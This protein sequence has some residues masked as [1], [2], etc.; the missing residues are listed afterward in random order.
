[1]LTDAPEYV[2]GCSLSLAGRLHVN[3][4]R[5]LAVC[6]PRGGN[7][8]CL[9]KRP[10]AAAPATRHLTASSTSS[11][12]V[13]LAPPPPPS[14]DSVVIISDPS[15]GAEELAE[16]IEAAGVDTVL[17]YT[18]M[19][20]TQE[21][22][23]ISRTFSII[24]ECPGELCEVDGGGTVQLFMAE[25]SAEDAVEVRLVGLLLRGGY[26]KSTGGAMLLDGGAALWVYNSTIQECFA[27]NGGGIYT[28]GGAVTLLH[29]RVCGNKASKSGG[30]LYAAEGE[31]FLDRSSVWG[32]SADSDGGGIYGDPAS[33]V[34]VG[35]HSIVGNNTAG[36]S[37]GGIYVDAD[38]GIAVTDD[39]AVRGNVAGENGGGIFAS[40]NSIITVTW[41]SSISNNS[42]DSSGGGIYVDANSGIA[43]TDDSAVRGNVAGMSGGGI[44]AGKEGQVRVSDHSAVTNN[45][46]ATRHGGGIRVKT[47]SIVHVT[48]HSAVCYN[49]AD[50]NS[51]GGGIQ[52]GKQSEVELDSSS[53]VCANE[54]GHGGGV[55]IK[56][57]SVLRVRG[58]SSVVRNSAAQGS[59]GGMFFQ[60]SGTSE[61]VG[62]SAVDENYALDDGGGIYASGEC[63]WWIAQGS[64]VS[65]ND[66]GFSGGGLH[67]SSVR[68]IRVENSTVERNSA[69]RLG[70]GIYAETCAHVDVASSSVSNNTAQGGAG[71]YSF[72]PTV[73]HNVVFYENFENGDLGAFS[74]GGTTTGDGV[75]EEVDLWDA[76]YEGGRRKTGPSGAMW[77]DYYAVALGKNEEDLISTATLTT[78]SYVLKQTDCNAN[79][80]FGYHMY[81]QHVGNL[82][83]QL[84][85]VDDDD[86]IDVGAWNGQQHDSSE[87]EYTEVS[88]NISEWVYDHCQFKLRFVV[89]PTEKRGDIAID[90]VRVESCG[91]A[92]L[93][94]PD[95]SVLHNMAADG[96]GGGVFMKAGNLVLA[97]RSIIGHNW[98]RGSGG[99][100]HLGQGNISVRYSRVEHNLALGNGGGIFSSGQGTHV[101]VR[102]HSQVW[103]NTAHGYGGAVYGAP[104]GK[105]L[106]AEHATMRE[107]KAE[108]KGGAIYSSSGGEVVLLEHVMLFGNAAVD[109]GG[110]I[111]LE[112]GSAL[113]VSDSLLSNNRAKDGAAAAGEDRCFLELAYGT[114]VAN[115]SAHGSGGAVLARK[116]SRVLLRGG[117]AVLDNS[118]QLFGGG[119]FAEL[120]SAVQMLPG[121]VLEGNSAT[122]QGGS[123]YLT[124]GSTVSATDCSVSSGYAGD[125]GGGLVV[126]KLSSA[127]LHGTRVANCHADFG[128]GASVGGESLLTV[129]N[130]TFSN[131]HATETGGALSVAAEARLSRMLLSENSAQYGGATSAE[132]GSSMNVS[133]VVYASNQAQWGGGMAVSSAALAVEVCNSNFSANH[134]QEWGSGIFLVWP[135]N[136]STL[137]LRELQFVGNT[138][139]AMGDAIFWKTEPEAGGWVAP[140]TVPPECVS[141]ASD[142]ILLA[143]TAVG[144]RILQNNQEVTDGSVTCDS[145]YIISPLFQ[146]VAVD[147]YGNVAHVEAA[148]LV[149]IASLNA[150]VANVSGQ[151]LEVYE[152]EGAFF[153]SLVVTGVPGGVFEL[154]LAPSESSWMTARV[155]VTLNLCLLGE[156]YDSET[157]R[158]TRCPPGFLSFDNMSACTACIATEETEKVEGIECLG[159]A[160]YRIDQGGWI[161][162]NSQYCPT[163]ACFLERV[164]LCSGN[165]DA[166]TTANSSQR[167]GVG[168]VDAARIQEHLCNEEE[169][170]RGVV[171][172]GG[173]VPVVCSADHTHGI[174]WDDCH[175]CPSRIKLIMRVALVIMVTTGV[176]LLVYMRVNMQVTKRMMIRNSS[177]VPN[178]TVL[179]SDMRC[180]LSLLLGYLQV[181]S[182]LPG[183]YDRDVLPEELVFITSLMRVAN[184]DLVSML[185]GKCIMYYL[186]P[187]GGVAASSYWVSFYSAVLTPWAWPLLFKLVYSVMRRYTKSDSVQEPRVTV[188]RSDSVQEMSRRR[189]LQA[190]C[191][192]VSLFL[193]IL[194]HPGVST[195]IIMLFKCDKFYYDAADYT[196][197]QFWLRDDASIEC[198]TTIWWIGAGFAFAMVPAFICGFPMSLF[199]GMR[200]LRQYMKARLMRADVVR[201]RHLVRTGK[202]KLI[203]QD[204]ESAGDWQI[205]L[206]GVA[207]E[208]A[209]AMLDSETGATGEALEMYLHGDT[210]QFQDTECGGD[211]I[212]EVPVEQRTLLLADGSQIVAEMLKKLDISSTEVLDSSWVAVT[213]LDEALLQKAFE[214]LTDMYKDAYYYWPHY[215]MLRRI[216]QTSVV[217]VAELLLGTASALLFAVLVSSFAVAVH[218]RHTPYNNDSLQRLQGV[219]LINQFLVQLAL[220]Y[221]HGAGSSQSIGVAL[222]ALQFGLMGYS[223]VLLVPAYSL[224]FVSLKS[225]LF[226]LRSA[227]QPRLSQNYKRHVEPREHMLEMTV[228]DGAEVEFGNNSP[229]YAEDLNCN[230]TSSHLS[231]MDVSEGR[232]SPSLD[233]CTFE[234]RLDE[235]ADT[236]LVANFPVAMHNTDSV[237]QLDWIEN[238]IAEQSW[239]GTRPLAPR[240]R[241]NPQLIYH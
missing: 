106:V 145:N 14:D 218:I 82:S 131:N 237:P 4:P 171:C 130:S 66:A 3:G 136:G 32:N 10:L 34:T 37:G 212:A 92:L 134:A 41:H 73:S 129:V 184:I 208:T 107:N 5:G 232:A 153:H 128:G 85:V 225:G 43:V 141:C 104:G 99:G 18:S 57:N 84:Q 101:V 132:E 157:H 122:Y 17:L 230:H 45:T 231:G 133:E 23:I 60:G 189:T 144:S 21:L 79:V 192:A 9:C 227:M 111:Y 150:V 174:L 83:F 100:L 98:A 40:K 64:S 70:G 172:G 42:A 124:A 120:G 137:R 168:A 69:G 166:C 223:M 95:T 139:G 181:M 138:A 20:L 204:V 59:G 165:A 108:L 179:L 190:G 30:G 2:P 113:H 63:T 46:A 94:G 224:L 147:Y 112:K 209:I 180:I 191:A 202:W 15:R 135:N 62:G 154:V 77:G 206:F 90:E 55:Y 102:R 160:E 61:V 119:L 16:A 103:R 158:C 51:F 229:E 7:E 6:G 149:F 169:F 75:C 27:K 143:S 155:N 50:L 221:V 182:Q 117:V 26:H 201:N 13:S 86:W 187:K 146:Y 25:A 88:F 200:H 163:A 176:L 115:N 11:E 164:E 125:Q 188:C 199:F 49:V 210:F 161:S 162:P 12:N 114:E 58:R 203:P 142:T 65:G 217:V 198:L 78:T 216:M 72:M 19:V 219:I 28:I 87:A 22:P 228:L 80:S 96:D 67:M 121:T 205:A 33:A 226:K 56:P 240:L 194:I 31:V 177:I 74:S 222:L 110:G 239:D 81:G 207:P 48:R 91:T 127:V 167:Q 178:A 35:N 97:N 52:A 76:R 173:N 109:V 29:S 24:G 8:A 220:L 140:G 196:K 151:V 116:Q 36:A 71:I 215:E 126:A 156:E 93:L 197:M 195:S 1:M 234:E 148:V 214:Q 170:I 211:R 47:N 241:V 53:T 238:P 233:S 89:I 44:F 236:A 183:L 123:I 213:M 39:S 38:S 105:V 185:N 54:A 235:K 68:E 152:R 118:A 175:V 193:M 186:L 159:G